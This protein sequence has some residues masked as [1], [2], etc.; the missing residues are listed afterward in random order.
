MA[1][2]FVDEQIIE[3]GF[4]CSFSSC[5]FCWVRRRRNFVAHEAA[6]FA[7][8]SVHLFIYL[9][10]WYSPL[11]LRQLVRGYSCLFF[12]VY[13]NE[14]AVYQPK[15]KKEGKGWIQCLIA[16]DHSDNDVKEKLL[17]HALLRLHKHVG[18]PFQGVNKARKV[19]DMS[20]HLNG[21]MQLDTKSSP[22]PKKKKILF[23]ARM[24]NRVRRSDSCRVEP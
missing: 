17:F 3:V 4:I 12:I 19:F 1:I 21:P 23:H 11:P 15:K 20:N 18:L 10:L 14:Y 5:N 8:N 13:L 24:A 16:L 22:N 6:R 2:H 7:L 9:F